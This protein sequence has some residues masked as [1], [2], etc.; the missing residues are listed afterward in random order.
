MCGRVFLRV[1]VLLLME[2]KRGGGK[3]TSDIDFNRLENEQKTTL[4]PWLCQ[5]RIEVVFLGGYTFSQLN[6]GITKELLQFCISIITKLVWRVADRKS[7]V[8]CRPITKYLCV[9]SKSVDSFINAER[10]LKKLCIM[11]LSSRDLH[12]VL[13]VLNLPIQSTIQCGSNKFSKI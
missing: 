9:K 7:L 2:L 5:W 10:K 3:R 1:L 13:E 8:K 4:R 11:N 6:W 12:T